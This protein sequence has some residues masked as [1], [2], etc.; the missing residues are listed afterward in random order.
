MDG[1]SCHGWELKLLGY[2]QLKRDGTPIDVGIRQ[3]RL[4][5]A[6]AL[7]GA[8]SRH[9]LAGRLWPD[10]SDSQAAGSLRASVFQVT[11]QLPNLLCYSND[12]IFLDPDVKVDFNTVRWL[13][14][15][16]ENA[17]PDVGADA[18]DVLRN[19]DL[20]PGWYDDWVIFEQERL[21]QQRLDAL[22]TLA[23]HFLLVGDL[24]R[25]I[26]AAHVAASIEPL[27]ESAQLILLR[28]H[29]EAGNT[30]WALR[31]F[32][33]FRTR[34][35]SELGVSPSRRFAELLELQTVAEPPLT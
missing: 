34:L 12:S 28:G 24:N 6:L 13:I 26:D 14:A 20:L 18:T 27:R 32:N 7:L 9:F 35:R 5:A 25:A 21:Q 15:D 8:R 33:E 22:E 2:W 10:S 17:G 1:T 19:A 29:L 4:I 11:H 3:Q 31:V 23:K 16:I 30:A